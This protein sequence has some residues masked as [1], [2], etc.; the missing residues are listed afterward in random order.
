MQFRFRFFQRIGFI[1]NKFNL[2][3]SARRLIGSRIIESAAYSNQIFQL[4]FKDA[5]LSWFLLILVVLIG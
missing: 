4:F 3:Y 2:L 1:I 5:T